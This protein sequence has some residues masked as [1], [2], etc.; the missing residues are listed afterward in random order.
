MPPQP[1][2]DPQIFAASFG[3]AKPSS[4]KTI[5][6][7]RVMTFARNASTK[8]GPASPAGMPASKDSS[9]DHPTY[10]DHR[11]CQAIRE[12]RKP[13]GAH[14]P[15]DEKAEAAGLW[16]PRRVN[17]AGSVIGKTGLPAAIRIHNIDCPGT[18]AVRGKGDSLAV[19]R[20][21]WLSVRCEAVRQIP[22]P[23]SVH[24]DH[25]DLPIGGAKGG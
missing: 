8:A 12:L 1:F 21:G 15:S 11:D 6:V 16:R 4:L 22:L 18:I 19:R 13:W 24:V 7:G 20:P 10:A 5:A 2:L 23:A 25:V 14:L 17:A 9:A 3:N